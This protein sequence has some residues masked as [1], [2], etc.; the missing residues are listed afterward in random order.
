MFGVWNRLCNTFEKQFNTMNKK[1]L[2]AVL[3]G[4]S[5]FSLSAQIDS[6]TLETLDETQKI[7]LLL[8]AYKNYQ[9]NLSDYRIQ[10]FSG[11]LS[12][13]QE[14]EK[15]AIELF[16]DWPTSIDFISPSYRV[17]VGAFKNRL[18]AEKNLIAIRKKYPSAVLLKPKKIQ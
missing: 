2:I 6:L 1:G 15:E 16:K 8:G 4:V 3:A 9:F 5:T 18:E 7:E 12:Q 11:G 13:A 17:R 14:I 10:L